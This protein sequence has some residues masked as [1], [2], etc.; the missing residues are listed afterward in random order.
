M[1]IS[2]QNV[3]RMQSCYCILLATVMLKSTQFVLMRATEDDLCPHCNNK[4]TIPYHYL[5]LGP[6]FN[7]WAS[8]SMYVKKC[9]HTSWKKIIGF[10]K[11]I[12]VVGVL[13]G[14]L[15]HGNKDVSQNSSGFGIVKSCKCL[16]NVLIVM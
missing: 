8:D 3:G 16:P 2:G 14:T 7:L 4:G 6:V 1:N 12:R 10:I 15:R 9:C 13:K 5:G 11:K